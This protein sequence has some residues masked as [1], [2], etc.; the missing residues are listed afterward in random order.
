V[1]GHVD[2][3]KLDEMP[4]LFMRT[5]MSLLIAAAVIWAMVIPIRKMMGE[6]KH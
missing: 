3:E 6:A 2:P 4:R 5:S 1:G